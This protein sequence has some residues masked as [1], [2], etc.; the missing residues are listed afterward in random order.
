[1]NI[2][3]IEDDSS[4][5]D[6]ACHEL[7]RTIADVTI[8]GANTIAEALAALRSG[9]TYD[10]VLTD[11]RLPDGSGL[12]IVH[13]IRQQQIHS[14][15]VVLTGQGDEDIAVGAIKAGADDYVAKRS[16]Y[17]NRLPDIV[18]TAW[19]RFQAE[20]TRRRGQL[21]VLYAEHNADEI[22]QT[23]RH[24]A[25]H[26]PH[27]RLHTAGSGATVLAELPA[28][29]A[30]ELRYDVLLLEFNL[31]GV[32]ALDLVKTIRDERRLDLPVV[33]VT[34]QGDEELAAQ[35]LRL[36]IEA[37]IV[38]HVGY[39]F[40][41]PMALENAHYRAWLAREQAALRASEERFRRLAENAPDLIYR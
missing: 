2:L 30:E 24:L 8:T 18:R 34:S 22:D 27:I 23:R 41:L 37:Y 31:R 39:L 12:E 33:L 21:R 11:L 13:T 28:S 3:Y 4:D 35:S 16:G 32:N 6:L 19:A 29:P 20:S 25:Q 17:Y 9:S 40:Q 36:G 15:V 14:A 26:A 38:K 1:M 7:K 5:F 10:V